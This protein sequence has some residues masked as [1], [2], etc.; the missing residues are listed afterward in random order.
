MSGVRKQNLESQI[1]EYY[2]DLSVFEYFLRV[3]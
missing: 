1:S 3:I 2:L